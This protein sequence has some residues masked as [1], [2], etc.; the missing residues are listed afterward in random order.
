LVAPGTKGIQ[1]HNQVALGRPGVG[2]SNQGGPGKKGLGCLGESWFSA[3][4]TG[5]V[6]PWR[7]GLGAEKGT[8]PQPSCLLDQ[9]KGLHFFASFAL[10]VK[11][12]I[13]IEKD[14]TLYLWVE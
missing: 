12:I 5:W 3:K 2:K 4:R 1:I 11:K 10:S 7:L 8:K 13:I 14:Q 9:G 6:A